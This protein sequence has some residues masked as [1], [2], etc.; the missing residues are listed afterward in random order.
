[1]IRFCYQLVY[2]CTETILKLMPFAADDWDGNE[3]QLEKLK[4]NLSSSFSV[5][6]KSQ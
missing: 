2:W 3:L 1:M 6:L 4:R 5:S